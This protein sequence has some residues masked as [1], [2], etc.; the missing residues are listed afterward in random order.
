MIFHLRDGNP[1]PLILARRVSTFVLGLI[2]ITPFIPLALIVRLGEWLENRLF[3]VLDHWVL[4][5]IE[6]DVPGW[7]LIMPSGW[8]QK[9]KEEWRT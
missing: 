8:K 3:P 5:G 2:W 6:R 9:R 1:T 4:P 7:R